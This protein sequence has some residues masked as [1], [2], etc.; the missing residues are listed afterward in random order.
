MKIYLVNIILIILY[1]VIFQPQDRS[2]NNNRIFCIL[3]SLN[4]ILLSGLRH[5]RVGADTLKYGYY[6]EQAKNISW[7][8]LWKE[9]VDIFIHGSMGKD[10]G[11][12]VFQKLVRLLTT[13][14]RVYLI[15]I[16]VIFTLPLGIWIYRNSSNA[17]MS[18][19]IY[20]CLFYSFF[21]ITGT[22]QTIAT[23]MVVFVGYRYIKKQNIWIFLLLILIG[24][25]IHFSAICYLPFY[26]IA[27]REITNKY[28]F[29]CGS[30]FMGVFI[31]K[32]YIYR[33]GSKLIGYDQYLP[34]QGDETW[35]FTIFLI[36]LAIVTLMKRNEILISN[37]RNKHY[38]NALLIAVI[39]V[40][41]TFVNPASMRVIQYFSL[42]IILLVPEIINTF[43]K[44]ERFFVFLIA[45]STLILLLIKNNPTYI[46]FWQS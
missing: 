22:R 8:S 26:F 35:I 2:E 36:A 46:F 12:I 25:S 44:K 30:I 19:I 24:S 1:R 45:S 18:F 27:N 4:W 39:L 43:Q 29:L 38:I 14:Y 31:F 42:Y 6:F 20:S 10:P 37:T 9:P 34:N 13:N 21:S 7:L 17:L 15:I 40:L 23:A 3:A 41:F 11:Y 16:A 28:L 5:L 33:L 32:G